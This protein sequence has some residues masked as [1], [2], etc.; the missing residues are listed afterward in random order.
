[1]PKLLEI[2]DLFRSEVLDTNENT[3][4]DRSRTAIR[5]QRNIARALVVNASRQV[6]RVSVAVVRRQRRLKGE[7]EDLS[8]RELE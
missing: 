7:C 4:R 1:M 5:R 8:L 3:V 6:G 2:C